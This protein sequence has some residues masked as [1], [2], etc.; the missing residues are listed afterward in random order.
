MDYTKRMKIEDAI[1]TV[2]VFA[3]FMALMILGPSA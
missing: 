2:L 3:L 1:G